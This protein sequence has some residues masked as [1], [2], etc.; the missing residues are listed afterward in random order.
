MANPCRCTREGTATAFSVAFPIQR[1]SMPG[2]EPGQQFL[3]EHN[4]EFKASHRW[5][6]VN[7]INHGFE[8]ILNRA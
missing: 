5:P 2:S 7:P 8:G 4:Q 3:T 1:S 6:D